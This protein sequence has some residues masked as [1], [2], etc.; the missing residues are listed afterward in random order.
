MILGGKHSHHGRIEDDWKLF[1]SFKASAFLRQK[2]RSGATLET[3][4]RATDTNFR[5]SQ[6]SPQVTAVLRSCF[7][8]LCR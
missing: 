7:D 1:E 8:L 3:G 5:G 4:Q 6:S 2:L